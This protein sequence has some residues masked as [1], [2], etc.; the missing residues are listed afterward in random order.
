MKE[1]AVISPLFC[2]PHCTRDKLNADLTFAGC[3][4]GV[5]NKEVFGQIP[6]LQQGQ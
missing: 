4:L 6:H 3:Y 2:T 1:I 5:Y